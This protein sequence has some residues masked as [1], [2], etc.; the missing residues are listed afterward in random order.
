MIDAFAKLDCDGD[1]K[2]S[3]S[4]MVEFEHERRKGDSKLLVAI[5]WIGHTI[6]DPCG[7]E[8]NSLKYTADEKI[9]DQ[10]GLLIKA[11][12]TDGSKF[13]NQYELTNSGHAICINEHA[14]HI[15]EGENTHVIHIDE[16]EPVSNEETEI[17]VD[18]VKSDGK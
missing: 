8:S 14:T 13:A 9:L 17:K 10:N 16:V 18:D 5:H 4:E 11:E 7:S 6:L 3:L 12:G 15:A 1:E 2:I